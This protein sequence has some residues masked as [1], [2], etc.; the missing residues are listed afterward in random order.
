MKKRLPLFP[1]HLG[2]GITEDELYCFEEI[3]LSRAIAPDNDIMLRRE[4]FGDGLIL[5]AV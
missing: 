1:S 2:V 5:V 3:A 4:G